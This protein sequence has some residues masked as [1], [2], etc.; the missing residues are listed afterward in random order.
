MNPREKLSMVEKSLKLLTDE[1]QQIKQEIRILEV[2]NQALK[3]QLCQAGAGDFQQLINNSL[4]IRQTAR[5]K[6]ESL[7][8]EG[9]HVCHLFFG[10][11]REGECL[12]CR[13]LLQ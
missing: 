13:G 8:N 4:S 3:N 2:E 11:E 7:H 5:E 10:Q 6:L 1:I 9:Y 12:F